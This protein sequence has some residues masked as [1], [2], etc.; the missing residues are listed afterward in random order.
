[1]LRLM[2][3]AAAFTT[4]RIDFAVRPCLPMIR[5]RSSDATRSSITDAVS[6]W[7]SRTWTSSGRFTRC[8]ASISTSSFMISPLGR[9]SRGLGG[10]GDALPAGLSH[11]AVHRL[12]GASAPANPGFE[13]LEV[14]GDDGGILGRVVVAKLL[15][16]TAV[17][18]RLGGRGDDAIERSL[19]AAVTGQSDPCCHSS[20]SIPARDSTRCR[21]R[22]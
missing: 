16:E 20:S 17:A 14:E 19:L 13:L 8:F 4:V 7:V 2:R 15:D 12:G 18:R 3:E 11:E 21:G 22:K 5:P 9:S 6:P 1:T 10:R